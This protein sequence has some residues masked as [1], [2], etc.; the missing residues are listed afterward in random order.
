M[1]LSAALRQLDLT[2]GL[3]AVLSRCL[4]VLSALLTVTAHAAPSCELEGLTNVPADDVQCYFYRGTGAYRAE[5]YKLAA[6]NWKSLIALKSVPVEHQHL[7]VDAYNNLGFLYFYGDGVKQDKKTAIEYWNYA[8]GAGN[9][10][11]G[12][13]LCHAYGKAS[14]PMYNPKLALSY[15]KDSLRRYE[16]L[17]DEEHEQ[18]EIIRQL[19]SYIAQLDK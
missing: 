12:Y 1:S 7:K 11:S 10:E 2:S 3:C 17:K 8:Y 19:R 15:C 14:E 16:A 13:H 4:P 18:D 6:A 5:N 9:E